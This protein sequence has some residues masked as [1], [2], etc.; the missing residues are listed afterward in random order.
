MN[1]LEI[2]S[3]L[4]PTPFIFMVVRERLEDAGAE[5]MWAIIGGIVA[6]Y[7]WCV[8]AFMTACFLWKLTDA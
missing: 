8:I 7:L 5:E 1:F 6:G 3:L 2:L 4:S